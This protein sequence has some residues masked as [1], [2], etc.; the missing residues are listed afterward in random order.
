MARSKELDVTTRL[1]DQSIDRSK[2]IHFPHGLKGLEHLREFTL[3]QINENTPFL[4]LQSLEDP[5][6]GLLV[7]DP[8]GFVTDYKI[9]ISDAEQFLLNITN[10]GQVAVLVTVS[11]P[12]GKP[13]KT[14]L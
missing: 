4:L 7:T 6:L 8:Y 3:M 2:V 1:G 13:E 9:K 14:T 10:A 12:N 5:G 11:I